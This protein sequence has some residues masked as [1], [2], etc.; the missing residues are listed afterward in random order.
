[1]NLTKGETEFF[2]PR[3][4]STKRRSMNR[5]G[6]IF[7]YLFRRVIIRCVLPCRFWTRQ[8]SRQISH[9]NSRIWFNRREYHFISRL[10]VVK[11]SVHEQCW[12]EPMPSY[13]RQLWAVQA[14]LENR[15]L[16]TPNLNS[17]AA[18]KIIDWRLSISKRQAEEILLACMA[19]GVSSNAAASFLT[20]LV[21]FCEL[22]SF[23]CHCQR[24]RFC[25]LLSLL[26]VGAALFF[27]A[28]FV[29][30]CCFCLLVPLLFVEELQ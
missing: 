8:Y 18:M 25:L 30:L 12:V 20:R 9:K 10:L 16:P 7:C 24:C 15:K 2:C 26:F 19:Y 17:S 1:M 27:G 5:S 22:N 11:F 13:H 28:T 3:R 14:H 21:S 4:L 23:V 6:G 29:C